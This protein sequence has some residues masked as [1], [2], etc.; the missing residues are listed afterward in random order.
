MRH[1]N[2]RITPQVKLGQVQR[3]NRWGLTP[4]YYNTPQKYPV[5]DKEKPG[6]G[7]VHLI[8]KQDLF[9]F[10]EILPDWGNIAVGLNAVVLSAGD[11]NCMGWHNFGVVGI[12]A[13][14]KEIE[15]DDCSQDFYEDHKDILD[16]LNV[17]CTEKKEGYLIGFDKDTAKAFQLIHIFIHEL[18][19][20]HDRMNTKSKKSAARGEGYAELYAKKYEDVIIEEYMTTFKL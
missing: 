9:D 10:I 2:R 5:F 16:K 13:W 18:G 15:W 19:H 4:N 8:R 1:Y 17:P 3:K 6:K 11:Y 20:H 12:A 7:F 14:E